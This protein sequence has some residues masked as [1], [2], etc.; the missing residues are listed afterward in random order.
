MNRRRPLKRTVGAGAAVT[1]LFAAVTSCGSGETNKAPSITAPEVFYL[2]PVGDKSGPQGKDPFHFSVDDGKVHVGGRG[3]VDHTLT[4][5][6][7]PGTKDRKT[8]V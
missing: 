6:V 4:V 2:R 7:L 5:D 3:P 1:F 8:H